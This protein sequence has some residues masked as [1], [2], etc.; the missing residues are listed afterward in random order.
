M[1]EEKE[2]DVDVPK[3]L[4]DLKAELD[5]FLPYLYVPLSEQWST[6]RGLSCLS[7]GRAIRHQKDY[8]S[9]VMLD[10]RY[11]RPSVFNKLPQ[12]IK[13]RTQV[14]AVFG[15]AFAALRKVNASA[16]S[17]IPSLC[18]G[19]IVRHAWAPCMLLSMCV[20]DTAPLLAENAV[21]P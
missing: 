20:C 2:R 9:I 13:S 21:A 12:W 7:P 17:V 18:L 11:T 5:H 1:L 16:D 10:H 3:P 4:V 19:C 8:A 6:Q 14:K 15:A